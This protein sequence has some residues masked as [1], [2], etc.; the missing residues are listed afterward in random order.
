MKQEQRTLNKL[1]KDG[2]GRDLMFYFIF[3]RQGSALDNSALNEGSCKTK[4]RIGRVQV[5]LWRGS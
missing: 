3:S 5:F 2:P 1:L 4:K